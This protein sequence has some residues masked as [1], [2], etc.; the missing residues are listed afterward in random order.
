[1]KSVGFRSGF[2]IISIGLL[3]NSTVYLVSVKREW[4]KEREAHSAEQEEE[5]FLSLIQIEVTVTS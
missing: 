4:E 1:M 3:I 2:D 5:R